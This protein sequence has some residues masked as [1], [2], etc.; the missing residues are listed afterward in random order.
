MRTNE[1][2]VW[3]GESNN[4]VT[5]VGAFLRKTSL[6]E[7]PQI[8]NILRG[9]MSLIGPRNDIAGLGVRLANEI[10]YYNIRYI[11]KPGITGWAQTHQMYSPGNISPQSVEETKMRLAYDLFY[12]KNRSLLLD[13]AIAF[14]T[15][16]TLIGRFGSIIQV[17][18]SYRHHG[19]K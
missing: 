10:P 18:Y 7:L 5:R 15:F 4:K 6:D 12:V 11:I 14:R 17:G 19:K 13:I 8:I 16:S 9:E 1:N 3:L 2:G